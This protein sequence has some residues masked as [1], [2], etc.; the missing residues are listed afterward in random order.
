MKNTIHNIFRSVGLILL[1][2]TAPF[3]QTAVNDWQRVQTLRPK[4]SL[5]IETKDGREVSGRFASATS[6]TLTLTVKNRPVEISRD[7]VESVYSA[8]K[9]SR[10]K[11]AL[12]GAAIGG[13]VG[14]GTLSVYTMATKSDPL[15]AVAG[16]YGVPVG[17][18]IGAVGTSKV[19]RGE[20]IYRSP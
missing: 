20:L 5:I 14:V 16:L 17:A 6:F 11:R 4:T 15:T 9:G 10:F 2:A 1:S 18:V 13:L 3:A 8:R 12:R 7:S 19:K